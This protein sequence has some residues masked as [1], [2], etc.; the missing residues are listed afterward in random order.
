MKPRWRRYAT[1]LTVTL[2]LSS[3][4]TRTLAKPWQLPNPRPITHDGQAGFFVTNREF[5]EIAALAQAHSSALRQIE[6]YKRQID[7]FNF[8]VDKQKDIIGIAEKR[9][10]LYEDSYK[11]LEEEWKAVNREKNRWKYRRKWAKLWQ[12]LGLGTLLTIAGAVA[13]SNR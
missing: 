8:A 9:Y 2:L 1:F 7:D 6:L 4:P 13:I 3:L 11:L 10:K 12:P 5:K